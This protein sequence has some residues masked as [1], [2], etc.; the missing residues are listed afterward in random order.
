MNLDHLLALLTN[1][2]DTAL[3]R[4]AEENEDFE[5]GEDYQ[6]WLSLE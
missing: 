6:P 5:P 2:A 3:E 4:W 1:Y